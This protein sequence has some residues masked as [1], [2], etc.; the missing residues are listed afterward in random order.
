MLSDAATFLLISLCIVYVRGDSVAKLPETPSQPNVVH[1]T[2]FSELIKLCEEES[3]TFLNLSSLTTTSAIL[4]HAPHLSNLAPP[5]LTPTPSTITSTTP[6][7]PSTQNSL[8]ARIH[9]SS[10]RVLSEFER[11]ALAVLSNIQ[12]AATMSVLTGLQ[13]TYKYYTALSHHDRCPSI[14]DTDAD[15]HELQMPT[16]TPQTSPQTHANL[17]N[18]TLTTPSTLPPLAARAALCSTYDKEF[19]DVLHS[20]YHP[21]RTPT[22]TQS[23]NTSVSTPDSLPHT[24]VP[25]ASPIS[26]A[27]ASPSPATAPIRGEVAE[28]AA[29]TLTLPLLARCARAAAAG[30]CP[31]VAVK[32][33]PAAN[34]ILSSPPAILSSPPAILSSPP[35]LSSSSY[36]SASP[37]SVPPTSASEPASTAPTPASSTAAAA[38]PAPSSSSSSTQPLSACAILHGLLTTPQCWDEEQAHT[39]AQRIT[40]PLPALPPAIASDPRAQRLAKVDALHALA[41]ENSALLGEIVRAVR[42]LTGSYSSWGVPE[43]KWRKK[44]RDR[45]L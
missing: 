14:I 1:V 30:T 7:Q 19:V 34:T 17:T 35:A 32:Y 43:K 18:A 29:G 37:T 24:P 3:D 25:A 5:S 20:H 13:A 44:V 16:S 2:S 28:P 36:P 11:R 41:L 26:A 45:K 10:V 4:P 42:V 6:S 15:D 40:S 38:A 9:R 33:T 31:H 12:H 8:V 39:D 23:S 22:P 27:D 21:P